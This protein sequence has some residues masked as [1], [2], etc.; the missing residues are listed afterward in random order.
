MNSGS[1]LGMVRAVIVGVV[2]A[3]IVLVTSGCATAPKTPPRFVEVDTTP[4]KKAIEQTQSHIS[5]A[6]DKVAALEKECASKSAGWQ[7]AYDSLRDELN[8][9]YLSA[10]T[11]ED[12]RATAQAE[13]EKQAGIAN[14]YADAYTKDQ[15]EIKA[16][17]DSRHKYVLLCWKLGAALALA[18]VWIFR[19]PLIMAVGAL[20]GI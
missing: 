6:Q 2:V 15:I 9:A 17:K 5:T 18:A 4:I 20:G 11:A 1:V 7:K 8:Q 14:W 12:A 13:V 16:T 19:K 10:K 3:I